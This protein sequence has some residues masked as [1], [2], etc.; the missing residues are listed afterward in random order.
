M[1]KRV[2]YATTAQ[3]NALVEILKNKPN[4]ISGKFSA[5]FSKK[6][7]Q[8]EWQEIATV[9]NSIPG[10]KKDWMQWRK[11]WHDYRTKAKKQ[12]SQITKYQNG[13]GGGRPINVEVDEKIMDLINPISVTGHTN[14]AESI[15]IF[16]SFPD[17]NQPSTSGT[18]KLEPPDTNDDDLIVQD[19]DYVELVEQ[20]AVHLQPAQ[21]EVDT[22]KK[23]LKRTPGKIK[24][25]QSSISAVESLQKQG[26]IKLELK[27]TYYKKKLQ[28]LEAQ[29]KHQEEFDSEILKVKKEKI[30]LLKLI[31]ISV[32]NLLH[33]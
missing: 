17:L 23:T 3:K 7:A 20:N 4:L 27:E 25:L 29:I 1:D 22:P 21:N 13:T 2:G 19:H 28:L 6:N 30:K 15:V 14:V 33:K 18:Q 12:K 26:D 32:D 16:D 24:K 11:A 9:L 5:T 31:Q 8:I 10:A